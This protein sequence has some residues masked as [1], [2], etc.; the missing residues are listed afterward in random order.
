MSEQVN[1]FPDRGHWLFQT[2][3]L[4]HF[5]LTPVELSISPHWITIF[6]R[7]G[8]RVFKWEYARKYEEHTA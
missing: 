8:K 4:D 1:M 6:I 2:W 5:C 3:T 7:T